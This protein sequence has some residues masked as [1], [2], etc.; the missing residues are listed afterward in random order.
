MSCFRTVKLEAL[1]GMMDDILQRMKISNKISPL[2]AAKI[3]LK[4]AKE[5]RADDFV[6]RR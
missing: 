3:R 1:R 2:F 4:Y 5:M 6:A